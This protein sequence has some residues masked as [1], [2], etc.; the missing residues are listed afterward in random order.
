MLVAPA[1]W[2]AQP[3]ME[4][5][6]RD[7]EHS[8][9]QHYRPDPSMLR[10]KAEFHIDSFAKWAAA[11]FRMSRSILNLA[12][13]LLSRATSACSGFTTPEP[14]N[15]YCVSAAIMTGNLSPRLSRFLTLR[16]AQQMLCRDLVAALN[17]TTAF[18][19]IAMKCPVTGKLTN[20]RPHSR[21]RHVDAVYRSAGSV[22]L[23]LRKLPT[24][25]PAISSDSGRSTG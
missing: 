2:A 19:S 16:A 24:T 1:S 23:Y 11:F 21:C 9:H 12:F 3:S 8:A 14:M 22:Y 5:V 18:A 25:T 15:P 13:S 17:I 7:I 6:S 10:Q 20:W 4:T